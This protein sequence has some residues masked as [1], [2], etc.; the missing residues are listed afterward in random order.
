MN[1]ARKVAVLKGG[2]SLERNF[3]SAQQAFRIELGDVSAAGFA[4]L[5][6]EVLVMSETIQPVES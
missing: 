1:D 4:A 6:R 2:R 3:P 5:A